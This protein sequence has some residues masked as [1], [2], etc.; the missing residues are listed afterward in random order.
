MKY[1]YLFN[2]IK[3]FGDTT[4]LFTI[5][6]CSEGYLVLTGAFIIKSIKSILNI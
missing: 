3:Y 1:I 5:L 4:A 2:I 6:M